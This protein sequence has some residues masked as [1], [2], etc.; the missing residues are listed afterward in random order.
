[1]RDKNDH[2]TSRNK[3]FSSSMDTKIRIMHS[4]LV[5][6]DEYLWYQHNI[7]RSLDHEYGASEAIAWYNDFYATCTDYTEMIIESQLAVLKEE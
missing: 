5:M 2:I 6:A 3:Y 7:F 4:V 1:M